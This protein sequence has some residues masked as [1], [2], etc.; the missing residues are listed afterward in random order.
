LSPDPLVSWKNGVVVKT[1]RAEKLRARQ[2]SGVV[3][4]ATAGMDRTAAG[5]Q[6]RQGL[7][8]C[9]FDNKVP[10]AFEFISYMHV[11]DVVFNFVQF[12]HSYGVN[13]S[14]NLLSK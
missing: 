10:C 9:V 7:M 4:R 14:F 3:R 12:N 1:A 8:C 5:Q 13:A 11:F 6:K 2:S